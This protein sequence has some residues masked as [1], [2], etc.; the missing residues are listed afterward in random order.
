MKKLYLV[1]SFSLLL[2]TSHLYSQSDTLYVYKAGIIINKQSI[3]PV[4]VDSITFYKRTPVLPS[5]TVSIGTQT[6]TTLNLDVA[7]YR[8]GTP[9]PQ[10]TDPTQWAALK[11][12][13]WCYYE[14][15]TANGTTYGKLYNWY[16]V[17][18]IYDTDPNTPNKTLAPTGY[19]IP[20][21]AEWTA[22]TTFLGTEYAAGGQMKATTLW[23][24]P[25][26]SATNSSGFTGLPGGYRHIN[27][28]CYNL[29]R[30]GLFWSVTRFDLTRAYEWM[31][32]YADKRATR[33]YFNNEFGLSV[34][35]IKD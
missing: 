7:T 32:Y 30:S 35:C 8:D 11:T 28:T 21:D 9:I 13:A 5:G 17:A 20:T 1:L 29:G 18:G 24:I 12:G 34:R 22:L 3:K 16:A 31:L 10:V 4:D 2:P 26:S 15:N 33:N 23:E 25:N 19:H 14:N 27:G 6:W